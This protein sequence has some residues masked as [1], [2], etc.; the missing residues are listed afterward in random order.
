M[1]L[2]REGYIIFVQLL[3]LL[4]RTT[5]RTL[6]IMYLSVKVL[7]NKQTP[8]LEVTDKLYFGLNI[9]RVAVIIHLM[10]LL[11]LL[12]YVVFVV[13]N[14][15][16]LEEQFQEQKRSKYGLGG[17]CNYGVFG[18]N[19]ILDNKCPQQNESYQRQITIVHQPQST[20]A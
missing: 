16:M 17:G 10:Q 7:I 4:N 14:L 1:P 12:K 6:N 20:G 15:N 13:E 18:W 2:E 9:R 11:I 5:N 19:S 8:P 3:M